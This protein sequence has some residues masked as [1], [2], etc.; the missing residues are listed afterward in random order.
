[1]VTSIATTVGAKHWI[2]VDQVEHPPCRFCE[3]NAAVAVM[4]VEIKSCNRLREFRW[5][6]Q[7]A[8]RRMAVRGAL[9]KRSWE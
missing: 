6:L 2:P 8:W 5:N 9:Q 4:V 7:I 3:Q 1:M